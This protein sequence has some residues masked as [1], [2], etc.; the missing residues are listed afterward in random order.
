MK[1]GIAGEFLNVTAGAAAAAGRISRIAAAET[2]PSRPVRLIV[3]FTAGAASDVVAR[4]FAHGAGPRYRPADRGREQARRRIEHRRAICRRAPRNDGYTLFLP[5][6][7]SLTNE[8]VNPSSPPLDMS[9]DFAPIAQIRRGAFLPDGQSG[10]RRENRRRACRAGQGKARRIDLWFGRR[11]QPAASLR[12]AV[13][14]A[15][16]HQDG[17]TCLIPAARKP[18]PTWSPAA[19]PCRLPSALRCSVRSMPASSWRWRR[20]AA[21][22]RAVLPNVPTMAEAGISDFDV[23]LWLGLLAPARHAACR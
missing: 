22:G 5:A 2:Y 18:S 10:A 6:L 23:N 20:P 16:R 3:G 9:K 11:R 15:H 7:S 13:R 1:F 19:S 14:A 8:I 12:R 17:C 4:I 21:S